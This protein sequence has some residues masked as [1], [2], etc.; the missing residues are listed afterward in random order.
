MA[1][2]QTHDAQIPALTAAGST[3]QQTETKMNEITLSGNDRTIWTRRVSAGLAAL[4]L[5]G[6]AGIG[7]VRGLVAEQTSV[8][9]APSTLVVASA[10]EVTERFRALKHEQAEQRADLSMAAPAHAISEHYRELKTRQAEQ[11]LEVAAP[12]VSSPTAP[13]TRQRFAALKDQQAME[14]AQ[15]AFTATSGASPISD[16]YRALKT[17]QIDAMLIGE[18]SAAH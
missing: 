16:K 7:T 5:L 6:A 2:Q 11:K 13:S 14:R 12:V 15:T 10:P 3:L 17:R 4:A 8:A 1:A 9:Q 18:A